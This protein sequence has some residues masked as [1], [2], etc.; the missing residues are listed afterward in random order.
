MSENKKIRQSVHFGHPEIIVPP[1]MYSLLR[2]Q[3]PCQENLSI[4]QYL[5]KLFPD[6]KEKDPFQALIIV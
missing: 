5:L 2:K 3:A 6:Y 4:S 1:P